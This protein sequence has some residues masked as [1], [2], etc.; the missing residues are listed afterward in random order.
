MRQGRNVIGSRGSRG[1]V[2]FGGG[3]VLATAL[4]LAASGTGPAGAVTGTPGPGAGEPGPAVVH[5]PGDPKP[6]AT[7]KPGVAKK[8][9]AASPSKTKAGAK[10]VPAD[11]ALP[12][13]GV[14][15]GL[16]V[17]TPILFN[18]T[19]GPNIGLHAWVIAHHGNVSQTAPKISCVNVADG[20]FCRDPAGLPTT[21]PKGLN[22]TGGVLPAVS[23]LATT[24]APAFVLHPV[25]TSHVFYPAVTTSAVGVFP[26]GSVGANCF[27]MSVQQGCGYTPL[28]SLTNNAGES[29][30]N[31]LTGFALVGNNIY[32]TTTS[33]LELCMNILTFVPCN[34][35]P[36][37]TG[38]Q[39][40][41]DVAGLGPA[42]YLGATTTI[43][44]RVYVSSNP[45]ANSTVQHPPVLN[46]FD[47]V[48]NAPCEGWTSQADGGANASRILAIFAQRD[49]ADNEVGVCT[50]TG[51]KSNA[52]P[53]V[54]CH[55]FTGAVVATPAGLQGIFPSGGYGS[56]VFAPANAVVAGQRRLYFPFYTED[57]TYLGDTL[58][59]NWATTSA[60]AGF[61]NP[62]PH[63]TVN[64]GRTTD[65]G[66]AY[67]ASVG[68]LIG[69][70]D[71]SYVFAVNPQSGATTC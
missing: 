13:T 32:G 63:P 51:L 57:R 2:R 66:Y 69:A 25:D 45:S 14:R 30:V 38:F 54:T 61:P 9:G 56:V 53:V 48:V 18:Q 16:D 40:N 44:G 65:Y 3:V 41:N 55:D 20:T 1:A 49:E 42:D 67:N 27:D 59:Y 39:P 70:G 64:N 34:G 10:K 46:C 50:V 4:T 37:T 47:P 21:W 8:P 36:Y 5:R 12:P 52:S 17:F 60:C 7:K 15:T 19:V 22:T 23:N 24:Q 71:K 68:C 35:Q 43:N 28:A 29:N 11:T 58:C 26:D 6:D 33:G 31:G 62:S